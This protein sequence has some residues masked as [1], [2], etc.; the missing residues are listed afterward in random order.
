MKSYI[1]TYLRI[2]PLLVNSN[3]NTKNNST[4]IST[5]SSFIHNNNNVNDDSFSE[6][7][8]NTINSSIEYDI[9]KNIFSL[10]IP[11]NLRTGY[12][13]NLKKTYDFHFNGIFDVS[14][15][16]E[17]IFEIIGKKV[18]KNSIEGYNSTVFCYGQTGSGKTY[19]MCGSK[20]WKERGIIPRLLI[21]LFKKIRE[22]KDTKFDVFISYMEIYNEN[23][24][25]LLDNNNNNN[26][27]D[28]WKKITVYEDNN[29]N[30]MLKNLGLIK[31][32]NE[33][34]ALDL[35]ITGNYIRHIGST[36]MNNASSRS[37]AIFNIIIESNDN[38]LIRVSKLN[39]VDLAGS[40]RIK[41]TNNNTTIE[42]KYI[43]LSLSFL[44][45]VIIALNS[46]DRTH[47]PYR[48]S[49]MTTILKDSLGGNCKTILI[50]TI[51]SNINYIEES[52][53]S[54]RFS[55]RCS[56]VT[57]KVSINECMDLNVL[58]N[59]LIGENERLKKLLNEKGINDNN[60]KNCLFL[61]PNP[62]NDY[63]KDE[64]KIL[65]SEYLNNNKKEPIKAKNVNQLYFIIDF[66]IE[67][68]DKK[69]TK[70]NSKMKEIV[71]VKK[72]LKIIEEKENE[73]FKKINEIIKKHGLK[74]YFQE[75]FDNENNNNNN[76]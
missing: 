19:T 64:C 8:N 21:N 6:N 41:S 34:Q 1:E 58:V 12:V 11:E 65:I 75:F 15:T 57:N 20:N 27:I 43:N 49:L 52:I 73:K 70:Y 63:E 14:A 9:K 45:Q 24:Y 29:N 55:V 5:L 13:N 38:N 30:I 37:H 47:I 74:K 4:N 39:L 67:Y 60:D 26:N 40:E 50:A 66:L 35:L 17:E 3:N 22:L 28:N 68:I 72:K 56:K 32:E 7:N 23:A 31:V 36:T 42:T 16:Q 59:K 48:N 10:K 69:E 33:Q 44:E 46:K 18:I 54:I 2:K 76:N 53:S 25:D 62:L 51:S 71:E 61:N